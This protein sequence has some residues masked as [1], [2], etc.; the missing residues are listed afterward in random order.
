MRSVKRCRYIQIHR[1]NSKYTEGIGTLDSSLSVK[2]Q[3]QK[4]RKLE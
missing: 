4:E 3:A 1:A 2:K